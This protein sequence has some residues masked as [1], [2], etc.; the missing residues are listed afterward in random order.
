MPR[1]WNGNG[2]DVFMHCLKS[3]SLESFKNKLASRVEKEVTS[4]EH[5]RKLHFECRYNTKLVITKGSARRNEI[6][7]NDLYV[8]AFF[9]DPVHFREEEVP[10]VDTFF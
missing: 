6:I 10:L 2:E 8:T 7:V 3:D 9:G 5:V 1:R 4:L